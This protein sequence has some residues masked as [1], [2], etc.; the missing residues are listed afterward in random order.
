MVYMA[1][2]LQ[3]SAAAVMPRAQGLGVWLT[4]DVKAAVS[5]CDGISTCSPCFYRAAESDW[6]S[7]TQTDLGLN[8]KRSRSHGSLFWPRITYLHTCD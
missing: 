8:S 3:V 5:L 4:A 7:L 6:L 1:V 2:F